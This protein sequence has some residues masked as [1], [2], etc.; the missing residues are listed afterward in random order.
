MLN[1]AKTREK[2]SLMLRLEGTLSQQKAEL[3]S[4]G[5]ESKEAW[6]ELEKSIVANL[7]DEV[8]VNTVSSTVEITISKAF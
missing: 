5:G 3:A 4:R 1:T 6:D 8:S 2:D 7:A